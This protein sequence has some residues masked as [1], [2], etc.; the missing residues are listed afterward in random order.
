MSYSFYTSQA[1]KRGIDINTLS[2]T[3]VD[4]TTLSTGVY[5]VPT[6]ANVSG[7]VS[8]GRHIVLL[9]DGNVNINGSIITPPSQG[10]LFILAVQ[11]NIDILSTVG[12]AASSTTPA[13]EGY[14]SA[15]GSINILSNANCPTTSDLRLNVGGAL[16]ANSLYPFETGDSGRL[17]NQRSLCASNLTYPSLLVSSRPDFLLQMTDFYKTRYSSFREVEP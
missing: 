13:L 17:I 3:S 4:L 7:T 1:K 5:M 9:S 8:G 15:E 2:S 14:F 11:G 12:G 16:I 6:E 10:N